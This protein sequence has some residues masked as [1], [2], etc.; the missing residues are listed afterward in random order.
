MRAIEKRTPIGLGEWKELLLRFGNDA[1]RRFERLHG[2]LRVGWKMEDF[3][4][5]AALRTAILSLE[6]NAL[7]LFSPHA[8]K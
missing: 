2:K 8:R 7:R 5:H 1:V 3:G 6:M 4:Y